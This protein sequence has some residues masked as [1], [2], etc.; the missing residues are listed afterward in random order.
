[1]LTFAREGRSGDS[2]PRRLTAGPLPLHAGREAREAIWTLLRD[3]RCPAPHLATSFRPRL[4]PSLPP[5]LASPTGWPPTRPV[6]ALLLAPPRLRRP[7]R[8]GPRPQ[9]APPACAHPA[10]ALRPCTP[11]PRRIA[12]APLLSQTS[13][14]SLAQT[15]PSVRGWNKQKKQ[16]RSFFRRYGSHRVGCDAW[17]CGVCLPPG[18][19]RAPQRLCASL[20]CRARACCGVQFKEIRT[21]QQLMLADGFGASCCGGCSRCAWG[22][23]RGCGR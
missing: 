13:P 22:G 21:F 16:N 15:S 17:V 1:M 3:A 8:R 7:P 20:I 14:R 11:R 12:L 4:R 10:L 23:G 18:R 2:G 9:H 6:R 5:P 19:A